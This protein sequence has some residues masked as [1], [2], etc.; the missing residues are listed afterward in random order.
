MDRVTALDIPY[1][2]LPPATLRAIVEEYVTREGTDY[3]H[4]NPS[5]EDKVGR[6]MTQLER[7]EARISWDAHHE[8]VTL[9]PVEGSG[10]P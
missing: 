10:S 9:L 8:T 2:S 6:V 7:G 1:R 4:A 5:L 3:G